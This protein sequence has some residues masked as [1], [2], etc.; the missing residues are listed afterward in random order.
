MYLVILK[1]I[2]ELDWPDIQALWDGISR[3][4]PKVC[5]PI[6]AIVREPD[7]DWL[8][9]NSTR[10]DGLKI[11]DKQ[12]N[13]YILSD[14]RLAFESSFFS[15][16]PE[17]ATEEHLL[18]GMNCSKEEF[19]TYLHRIYQDA[20]AE[21]CKQAVLKRTKDQTKDEMGVHRTLIK[22]INGISAMNN[23]PFKD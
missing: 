20:L 15:V 17:H 13:A 21:W 10:L 9:E 12:V 5:R 7:G 4:F 14:G 23:N 1:S 22:D 3:I 11:G 8:V 19:S 2:S 16:L 6:D 18:E